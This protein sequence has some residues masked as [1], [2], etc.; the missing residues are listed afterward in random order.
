ML[1]FRGKNDRE[2]C[3]IETLTKEKLS[4]METDFFLALGETK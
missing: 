4:I 1:S 3:N 2:I